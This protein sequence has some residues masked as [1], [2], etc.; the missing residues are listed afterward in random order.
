M[1]IFDYEE[2]PADPLN[3][4]PAA[5]KKRVAQ[6]NHIRKLETFCANARHILENGG[7]LDSHS[8]QALLNL[9]SEVARTAVYVQPQMPNPQQATQAAAKLGLAAFDGALKDLRAQFPRMAIKWHGQF[10]REAVSGEFVWRSRTIRISMTGHDAARAH[11]VARALREAEAYF[12][13]EKPIIEKEDRELIANSSA[14][15]ERAD[16]AFE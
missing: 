8:T 13:R 10:K 16:K 3:E 2:E 12:Q 6:L 4:S 9:K 5:A 15:I 7:K 1:G 14:I 11:F